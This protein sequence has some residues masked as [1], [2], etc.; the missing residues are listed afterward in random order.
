LTETV[1]L[2]LIVED[3][4]HCGRIAVATLEH[5]GFRCR[6]ATDANQAVVALA[7]ERPSL[8]VMDFNLPGLDGL[9]LTRWMKDDDAT[10][11]IPV[12]AVTAYAMEGDDAIALEFGC[13]AYIA[14]P[15]DP[16]RLVE[17][18]KRLVYASRTD[19]RNG[20]DP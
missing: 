15:Y 6:L 14:K 17:E 2:V 18:A 8:V 13:S 19:S 20:V 5:A 4:P 16:A 10:C 7:G 3:D 11:D 1:P 12:L 9:Q